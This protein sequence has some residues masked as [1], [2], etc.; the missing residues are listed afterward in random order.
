[1]VNQATLMGVQRVNRVDLKDITLPEKTKTYTPLAHHDLVD[2]TQEMTE[3]LLGSNWSLSKEHY[4]TAREGK[5]LF[6]YL[7]YEN[8]NTVEDTH[9]T[10]GFRNSYD[11]SMSAGFVIGERVLVCSNLMFVGEITR[12][13]KHT[14]EAGKAI[15][16]LLYDIIDEAQEKRIDIKRE[17]EDF[18]ACGISN[19]DAYSLLGRLFGEDILTPR[20][21]PVVK[22][23]WLKPSHDH[24]KETLWSF[25]QS[26][27][28]ALKAASPQTIMQRHTGLH[29]ALN[30]YKFEKIAEFAQS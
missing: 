16:H 2:F 22:R 15:R 24:G 6:G 9:M 10:L 3:K 14:G 20:N 7:S 21:L 29:T 30:D 12:M 25:Y 11:K 23:E 8:K 13:R 17:I 1:M 28:E 27:T 19:T 26:C 4:G 18:K 5:Q